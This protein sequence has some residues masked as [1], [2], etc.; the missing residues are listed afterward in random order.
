MSA[1]LR[2]AVEILAFLDGAAIEMDELSGNQQL[3]HSAL[4]DAELAWTEHYDAVVDELETE[5]EKLPGEDVR[6]SIARRRG[7][8]DLWRTYRK[9]ERTS[10]QI[11][12]RCARLES[13]VRA[14]QSELKTVSAEVGMADWANQRRA[15]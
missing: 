5:G 9:L 3:N 4:T 11:D 15:A 12:K 6:I 1:E 13:I 10:K 7:G 14:C 8:W 2:S